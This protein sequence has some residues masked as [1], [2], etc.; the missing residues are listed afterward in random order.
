[1]KPKLLLLGLFLGIVE[2]L[3]SCKTVDKTIY[4][5]TCLN[6][7]S[8]IIEQQRGGKVEFNN[9]VMEI[10][11]AKGCTAWFKHKLIAPVKIEYDVTVIGNKGPLDRVS[12]LNCF[13]MANDPKNPNDF[14]KDSKNR[15]GLFP[16]YHH[17]RLYYVGYGGHNNTKTRFR[18]YDGNV[19]RPLLPEHDL[20]DKKFMIV[21]NKKIHFTLIVNKNHVSYSRDGEAIFTINDSDPY[22]SGYFGIRTVENHMK[23]ENLKITEIK[24]IKYFT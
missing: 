14:F 23:I 2:C 1:M 7:D 20:S 10:T 19:E 22:T 11:D 15:Q 24:L 17:L 3:T 21:P 4:D 12:D 6:Q 16:N 13:W 18:R 8:W 9:N 5:Q